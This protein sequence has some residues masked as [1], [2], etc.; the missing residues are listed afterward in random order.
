M[1]CIKAH[2]HGSEETFD[3]LRL[4]MAR[5]AVDNGDVLLSKESPLEKR[6]ALFLVPCLPFMQIFALKVAPAYCALRELAHIFSVVEVHAIRR[7]LGIEQ[8]ADRRR[9]HGLRI[10][11][12][13]PCHPRLAAAVIHKGGSMQAAWRAKGNCVEHIVCNF[14]IVDAV[15][16]HPKLI[17]KHIDVCTLQVGRHADAVF[18]S[19]FACQGTH[20]R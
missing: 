4:R 6:L 11:F 5:D 2:V 17:G 18:R 19:A 9:G 20:C 7:F 15:V 1:H 12:P 3:M 13:R 14:D 16:S 10:A 8:G